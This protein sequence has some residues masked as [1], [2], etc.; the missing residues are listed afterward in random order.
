MIHTASLKASVHVHIPTLVTNN[1]V[2]RL[3]PVVVKVINVE[4]IG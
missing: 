3:F 4:V 2:Y 1:L